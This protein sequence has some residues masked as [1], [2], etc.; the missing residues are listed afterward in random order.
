M[1]KSH[2][3]AWAAGFID[4]DGFIT[5][6]NRNQT[7]KDKVYKGHYL[8]IGACQANKL[9]LEELQR[10]FGGKI[11]IKNSGPNKEGYNRKTQFL[12]CLS[13]A[14]AAEVIEQ[15]LPYLIHKKEVALLGLEFQA[16]M[17]NFRVTPSVWDRREELKSKIQTINSLS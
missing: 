6:Q 4:G 11:I 16:T 8:R 5:I 13:T 15:L 1:S 12:W 9:P 3:L 14:Q 17:S 10:L 7:V 2:Q